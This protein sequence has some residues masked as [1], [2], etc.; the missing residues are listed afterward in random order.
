MKITKSIRY[1]L[2][3]F[4]YNLKRRI[5]DR[6][7]RHLVEHL[8]DVLSRHNRELPVLVISYNNGVYVD[9]ITRQ[10]NHYDIKPVIIDNCSTSDK[11]ISILDALEQSGNADVVRSR[12]N[13]GHE[14]GFL[15]PVYDILPE[16]FCYTDPDLQLNENLPKDFLHTLAKLTN[17]F[18]VYKA[19]FALTLKGHGPLKDIQ[20]HSRHT[21][22]F[23]YDE[24][25]SIEEF[26]SRYWIN[27]LKHDELELYAAPI[28]TTFALYRK[29]NYRGDFH[30]A[31]RVA[32]DYSAIHIP[33]FKNIDFMSE[34][35][36]SA[37]GNKNVSSNWI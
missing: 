17:E 18:K 22:P 14:V 21:R 19:G 13:L 27:R 3:R 26:E 5:L 12:Y 24:H 31:I 25:L 20:I 36:R 34:E 29:T 32:G 37:Y 23:L 16:T 6:K 10:L 9:N 33:W 8:K 2:R 4:A 35:D 1:P 11:T 15:Q 28:D 7:C 30:N